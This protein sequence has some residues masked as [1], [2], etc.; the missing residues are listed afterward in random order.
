MVM[1]Y[2]DKLCV[3]VNVQEGINNKWNGNTNALIENNYCNNKRR[4]LIIFRK[5]PS[6]SFDKE[7]NDCEIFALYSVPL[8]MIRFYFHSFESADKENV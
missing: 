1:Y 7:S 5:Q 8:L 6:R 2:E 3:I 4:N